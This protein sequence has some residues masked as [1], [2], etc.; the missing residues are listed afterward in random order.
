MSCREVPVDGNASRPTS[1]SPL[2]ILPGTAQSPCRSSVYRHVELRQEW[3]QPTWKRHAVKEIFYF[4]P[5]VSARFSAEPFAYGGELLAT[6]RFGRI[7]VE[8]GP[9]G[10][11]L[12]QLEGLAAQLDIAAFERIHQ[13]RN[14]CLRAA[15]QLRG[16]PCARRRLEFLDPA[17]D[18]LLL[19]HQVQRRRGALGWRRPWNW[20]RVDREG[21]TVT[22]DGMSVGCRSGHRELGRD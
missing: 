19:D 21:G 4:F 5:A 12:Q 9:V 15:Q 11:L 20:I 3:S 1:E 10:D 7:G 13:R 22:I 14:R 6:L 16:R 18:L 17:V 2:P 8:N